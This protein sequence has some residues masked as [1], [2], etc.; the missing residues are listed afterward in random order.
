M[1]F[2][3]GHPPFLLPQI[4][5]GEHITDVSE[6]EPLFFL[7]KWPHLRQNGTVA[8][9]PRYSRNTDAIQK[10]KFRLT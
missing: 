8:L 3:K 9:L 1:I 10:P 4:S 5:W 7:K 6:A 2:A